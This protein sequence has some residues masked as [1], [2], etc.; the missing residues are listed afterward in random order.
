MTI[1]EFIAFALA[2]VVAS[3]SPG[4]AVF[5]LLARTL[6]QGL[7]RGVIMSMGLVTGDLFYFVLVVAGLSGL[8]GL[9]GEFLL[10]LKF[11]GAAYLIFLG[12]TYLTATPSTQTFPNHTEGDDALRTE[13]WLRIYISGL[14]ITLG[15]PKT[16]VFFLAVLPALLDLQ[17]VGWTAS[18]VLGSTLFVVSLGALLIYGA[19]AHNARNLFQSKTSVRRLNQGAG[20]ILIVCGATLALHD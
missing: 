15:N 10:V 4:P 13:G 6:G 20:S 8:A 14:L 7:R 18:L 12:W 5:A 2:V 17:K 9:L 19:L 3:A 1:T 11:A 16:M